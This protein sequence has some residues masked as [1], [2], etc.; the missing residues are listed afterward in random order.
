MIHTLRNCI[1]KNWSFCFVHIFLPYSSFFDGPLCFRFGLDSLKNILFLTFVS[2]F[3]LMCL[4]MCFYYCSL[5][6]VSSYYDQ[7]WSP[8]VFV[9][10]IILLYPATPTLT[11]SLFSSVLDICPHSD[12]LSYTFILITQFYIMISLLGI[13]PVLNLLHHHLINQCLVYLKLSSPGFL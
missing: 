11:W 13:L 7:F 6:S 10:L 2:Y 12:P 9:W 4:W 8:H 5:F 3:S 1:V